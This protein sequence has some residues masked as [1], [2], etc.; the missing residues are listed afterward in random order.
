MKRVAVLYGGWSSERPVSLVSGQE[1]AKAARAAGYDVVDIDVTRDLA[2]QLKEVEPDVILNGLHGPWGEDGCV[3]GVFEVLGIPYSHSG[4]LAS[5]LAMDKIKS[6]AVFA[7]VGLDV[8]KDVAVTR[9]EVAAAHPLKPPYVVKPVNE[10]SSFGVLFVREGANGPA[11][12]V[13]GSNWQYGDNLMA[14][15]YISGRELTVAVMGDRALAVTEITTLRE[16]YDFDAKYAD[17]GSRHVVPADLPEAITKAALD[18]ALVAHRA[19]GCRGVSRSDF[20]FDEDKGRLVILE[21]NTQPGMTPTSLVPE[22][23]A[24]LGMSFED[25]VAWMI[26]DASCQR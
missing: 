25:L 21:T 4:V 1:M 3:Q 2:N 22:Q 16:F 10:G 24:H 6:K 18:A 14:E 7:G 20:R 5:S 11:T 13:L 15:E 8:A 9:E 17:G 19:L 12:E 23:A 26:E